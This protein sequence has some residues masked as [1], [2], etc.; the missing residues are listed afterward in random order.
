MLTDHAKKLILALI[1]SI[2]LCENA[3]AAIS[4]KAQARQNPN[5]TSHP[6]LYYTPQ[7]LKA[8]KGRMAT[9]SAIKDAWNKLLE[10]ADSLVDEEL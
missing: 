9:D 2:A 3:Q 5:W 6:R 10:R 4:S 7:R 8:F 1:L